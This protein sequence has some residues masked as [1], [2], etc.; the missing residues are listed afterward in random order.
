MASPAGNF[1][2]PG[3]PLTDPDSIARAAAAAGMKITPEE[4]CPPVLEEFWARY[5]TPMV[6][7]VCARFAGYPRVREEIGDLLVAFTREKIL[8]D[9]YLLRMWK[10]SKAPFR[11]Y[12]RSSLTKYVWSWWK[13]RT[14]YAE[15]ER[16]LREPWE[17]HQ[18]FGA[19]DRSGHGYAVI[20]VSH[21]GNTEIQFHFSDSAKGWNEFEN[22][23]LEFG[24]CPI[25]LAN[26]C[27]APQQ[28]LKSE[29][30]IYQADPDSTEA[31]GVSSLV[32]AFR[33]EGYKWWPLKQRASDH[34]WGEGETKAVDGT[35]TDSFESDKAEIVRA[36]VAIT[37]ER[38]ERDCR[39]KRPQPRGTQMWEVFRLKNLEPVLS[40]AEPP[41][42][43]EL[44]DR[45]NVEPFQIDNMNFDAN[46]MFT[47]Q[48]NS[49]I[50]E[51][52][53]TGKATKSELRPLRARLG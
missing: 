50:S 15:W 49:V 52:E 4:P 1:S 40:N 25:G 23:M 39:E 13:K 43:R 42:S 48:L 19:L 8:V 10:P 51:Y 7:H 37:M 16:K 18:C 47:E 38:V 32:Q 28:L 20:V 14:E 46:E 29:H 33:K 31:P 35:Q 53:T 3:W 9:G 5:E 21:T 26:T 41:T 2:S 24:P 45:F 12:L 34:V 36:V 27:S 44:A 11:H 6:R 22:K 17:E 30:D